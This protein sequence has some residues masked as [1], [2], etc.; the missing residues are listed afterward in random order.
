MAEVSKRLFDVVASLVGILFVSPILLPVMFRLWRQDGDSPLYVA[1]RVGKGDRT[2]LMVKLRSMVSGADAMGWDSTKADDPRITPF[3]QIIRR[4]KLD[5]LPQLWNVL[6]GDMSLVGP[7]PNVKRET[8][9]YSPFERRL[10]E[11]RPG[12]TDFSSI[13][14]SDLGDILKGHVDPNLAYRHLVRPGKSQLG[15]FYV[16]HRSL[17]VD[18]QLIW[19]TGLAFVSKPRALEGVQRLLRRLGASPELVDL[20]GQQKLLVPDNADPKESDRSSPAC[21]S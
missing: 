16:E 5:E 20:A 3:G 14:F 8:T 1:Q 19:L 15:V 12:I 6:K 2:F 4:Y 18:L 9:L 21:R 7:R 10:L 13:V 17:W 11:V